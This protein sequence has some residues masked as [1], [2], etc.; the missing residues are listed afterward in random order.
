M[1]AP[2]AHVLRFGQLR[3]ELTA[4]RRAGLQ[5]WGDRFVDL[6]RSEPLQAWPAD[7]RLATVLANASDTRRYPPVAG[8]SDVLAAV[9]RHYSRVLAVPL[10]PENILL[11]SGALTGITLAL[12]TLARPGTE[13]AIPAPYYHA[14]PSQAELVG[15]VPRLV[16]TR[17]AG[18]R[19]DGSA[20]TA[21]AG[22]QALILANPVN[23]TTVSYRAEALRK[24]MAGL[25]P[26]AGL[27]ADEVYAEYVYEPAGFTSVAALRK[28]TGD[29]RWLVV[30]SAAKTLGRPGLR[31]GVLIGPAA[32]IAA[33]TDR[34]AAATGAA[35]VPAQLALREG[36]AASA[37]ADH[38]RPYR[39]RSQLAL[40]LAGQLGLA[41][42]PPAGTYYLWLHGPGLGRVST[43]VRLAR[44]AGVFVWPG[45]YFGASTHAR[46][47]LSAPAAG[48]ESGLARIAE[49]LCRQG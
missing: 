32:L 46:I 22:A 20:P 36:L 12:M 42:Q 8:R 14:Y 24:I 49:F 30:R 48:I 6:G 11:T 2:A 25:D 37:R 1:S 7:E 18:W 38:M 17:A 5:R 16:P 21:L 33:V 4:A 29:D 27:V 35:S 44:E 40:D 9:S 43:A 41:A 15:C 28:L 31:I 45:E 26:G 34:A 39:R 19:L 10:G 13:V 23:P 47:S 3:R